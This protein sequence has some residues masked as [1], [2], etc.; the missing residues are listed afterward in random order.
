MSRQLYTITGYEIKA[1]NYETRYGK[2]DS[3]FLFTIS[4][5]ANSIGLNNKN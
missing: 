1:L 3:E 4:G 5:T 2:T